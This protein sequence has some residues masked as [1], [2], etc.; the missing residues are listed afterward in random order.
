MIETRGNIAA[1]A[2]IGLDE[3][4]GASPARVLA[5][6]IGESSLLGTGLKHLLSGER[7]IVTE[8]ACGDE[9][10]DLP[11]QGP[12]LF[13]TSASHWSEETI[14]IIGR[15]KA[16]CPS[17]R[18]CM[19]AEHF[20]INCVMEAHEAGVDGFCLMTADK[21]V[22]T[23]SLELIALG[24][25]ILP[26]KILLSVLA[27][28]SREPD[29]QP[30][31]VASDRTKVAAPIAHKLSVREGEI[32]RGLMEGEPNKVIAR[33]FGLSEA[34]V[35]VHVKAI[36]RK[37]GAKNRTQAAMWASDHIVADHD[38]SAAPGKPGYGVDGEHYSHLR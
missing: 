12:V 23:K 19:L 21:E 33:R 37:I 1:L 15:L 9:L 7:F 29:H 4:A 32:L 14:A 18:V 17:G 27:R 11:K 16:Q 38:D 20:D 22:L 28:L 6:L 13:I 35:K 31:H 26:S 2:Q 25:D 30:R 10:P 34:T 3:K 5:I 24:E 36:L 8:M